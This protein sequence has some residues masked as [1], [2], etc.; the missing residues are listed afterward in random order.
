MTDLRC[1]CC[2]LH[3]PPD[4]F[5]KDSKA[6]LRG[7]RSY[8]CKDCTNKRNKQRD[9]TKA[10][11][12]DAPADDYYAMTQLE[13]AQALGVSRSCVSKIEATA[14]AKLRSMREFP[15]T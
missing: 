12:D 1:N 13:V 8:S 14:L 11:D 2:N 9:R 10:G 7:G 4:Q 5:P 6:R 3:K 15:C